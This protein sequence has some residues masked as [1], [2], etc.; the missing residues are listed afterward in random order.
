LGLLDD[1]IAFLARHL[2]CDGVLLYN[3]VG[4]AL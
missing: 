1:S 3:A 4:I 2:Y